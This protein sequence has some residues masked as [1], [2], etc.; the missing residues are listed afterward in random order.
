[1]SRA[2]IV[3]RRHWRCCEGDSQNETKRNISEISMCVWDDCDSVGTSSAIAKKRI[4]KIML[5]LSH[6]AIC[7]V[8]DI[9]YTAMLLVGGS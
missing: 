7:A 5:V 9:A 2:Y 3:L 8:Y 6:S 1:M 4:L